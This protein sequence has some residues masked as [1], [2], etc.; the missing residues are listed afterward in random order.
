MK[1]V[2]ITFNW[3]TNESIATPFGVGTVEGSN[4]DD[5]VYDAEC[6][7][8]S[9]RS[10]FPEPDWTHTIIA[11]DEASKKARNRITAQMLGI[12]EEEAKSD[13]DSNA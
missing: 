2:L 11:D 6:I 4:R 7:L 10:D 9:I 1:A 12:P 8:Q 3:K 13:G 5:P